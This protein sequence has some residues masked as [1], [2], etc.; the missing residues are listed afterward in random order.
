[1]VET[2]YQGHATELARN[3]SIDSH[4][5]IVCVG[6]DGIWSE[7]LNGLCKRDDC[8]AALQALPLGHVPAGSGNALAK[9]L[10]F[11][12]GREVDDS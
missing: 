5:G 2:Q 4:R 11:E 3:L 8:D 10:E 7:A 12:T 9:S 1:M 6:G